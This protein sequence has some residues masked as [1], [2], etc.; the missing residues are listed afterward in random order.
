MLPLYDNVMALVCV[1]LALVWIGSFYVLTHTYITTT[2]MC[3]T[4]LLYVFMYS[5]NMKAQ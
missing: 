4:F 3:L 5:S 1:C 2:F